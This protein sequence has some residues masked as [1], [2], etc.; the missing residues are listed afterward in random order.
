ML[1]SQGWIEKEIIMG[2]ANKNEH[3]NHIHN[4]AAKSDMKK[5]SLFNFS[6]NNSSFLLE[7]VFSINMANKV[8]YQQK[9]KLS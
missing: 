3:R 5:N 8:I 6:N 4:T 1:K 9:L 7:Y 2:L